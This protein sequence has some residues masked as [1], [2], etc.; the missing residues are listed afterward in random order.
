MARWPRLSED[1]PHP[2]ERN[3]CQ[4]CGTQVERPK[5]WRE[6]DDEDKP[7]ATVVVLC[8]PCSNRLINP[9]P[10]LYMDMPEDQ[11]VPG[12]MV[13]CGACNFRDGLTCKHPDLTYNGGLGLKITYPQP[14]MY[15]A[16]GRSKSGKRTGWSGVMY[17]GPPT[18]CA[19]LKP[20]IVK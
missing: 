11:P 17:Q 18:D 10:R 14:V 7:R 3:T 13:I 1:L 5:R 20:A 15:H 4:N 2:R 6:C 12:A 19:G 16:C 9:H 8:T